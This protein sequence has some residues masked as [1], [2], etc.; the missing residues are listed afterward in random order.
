MRRS[1]TFA[2]CF[3]FPIATPDARR[4]LV[5]G[6][7]L[8][9]LTF[10]G[11][12][13]NMGHRLEVVNHVWDGEQPYFRGFAPW[14]PTFRRGLL[15]FTAIA[16]YLAPSCIVSGLALL[17]WPGV[18]AQCATWLSV[19]LFL[20]GI[21][22]LPGGMTTNAVERDMTYLVRPDLALRVA[23]A[24]GREYVKAW[25]VAA[26][27]IALSFLG[28]LAGGIGFLYSSVW[29]WTVVGFAFTTALQDAPELH[30]S[31]AKAVG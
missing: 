13:L 2:E 30:R 24:G 18:F 8:L 6:G 15:A 22:A 25:L 31:S 27:A 17:T 19:S 29:A 11:W 10:P 7:T 9:L 4:D 1:P 26:C 28:L 21:F 3:R 20:L 5:L 14:G 16:I 23:L 12:I